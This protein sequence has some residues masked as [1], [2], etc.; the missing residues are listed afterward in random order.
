MGNLPAVVVHAENIHDTKAGSTPAKQACKG[1]PAIERFCA[2]AG[3]RGTF[4][5]D[6]SQTPGRG[7]DISE[8]IKPH[9]WEKLPWRWIVKRTLGWFHHS[10]RLSRDYEIL[11]PSAEA[12][13][14]I[15]HA[16]T[17]LERL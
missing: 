11:P 2:G 14:I 10:R 5:L 7:V 12:V 9:Q 4:A 15:S 8:K 6:A 1:Y 13:I 16:H 3:Y 17:F